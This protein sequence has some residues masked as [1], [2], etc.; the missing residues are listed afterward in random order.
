[1]RDKLQEINAAQFTWS[2][3]N[4]GNNNLP[5]WVIDA[6]VGITKLGTLY[7]DSVKFILDDLNKTEEFVNTLVSVSNSAS[8]TRTFINGR[9]GGSIKQIVGEGDYE[10]IFNIKIISEIGFNVGNFI[11]SN[12]IVKPV[13]NGNPLGGAN[14]GNF[15]SEP[16]SIP[17]PMFPLQADFHPN[18]SMTNLIQFLT[19]F[20]QNPSYSNIKVESLYLNDIFGIYNIVPYSI[21]TQQNHESTNTYNIIISAYS[22]NSND[23]DTYS[24][25]IIPI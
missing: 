3:I 13:G 9:K 2:K 25:E 15:I 8:I 14:L 22:D 11:N 7:N 10:V 12:V 20:Y 4:A 18:V 23:S 19:K 24:N 17:T 1:M 6:P 21:N 5:D 16:L